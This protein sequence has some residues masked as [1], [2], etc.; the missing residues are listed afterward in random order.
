MVRHSPFAAGLLLTLGLASASSAWARDEPT[1][2]FFAG[3]GY[4]FGGGSEEG[5]PSLP[6]FDLGAGLWLSKH[7]GLSFSYTG[8][9]SEDRFPV[10]GESGDRVFI[11]RRDLQLWRITVRRRQMLP[12]DAEFLLGLGIAWGDFEE[13]VIGLPPLPQDVGFDQAFNALSFELLLG[14]RISKHWWIRGG[15]IFDVNT[16]SNLVQPVGMLVLAF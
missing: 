4:G 11:G 7:W 6:T 9:P 10:R 8:G 3:G 14:K 16:E 15:A 5:A 12:G 13:I 2:E 1:V